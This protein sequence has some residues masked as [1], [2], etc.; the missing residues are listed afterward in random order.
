MGVLQQEEE[1]GMSLFAS[2]S[3]QARL[4]IGK[5]VIRVEDPGQ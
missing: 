4:Q 5:I 3:L 2:S 1:T